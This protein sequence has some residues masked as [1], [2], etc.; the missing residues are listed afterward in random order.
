MQLSKLKK[1]IQ[2]RTDN[3]ARHLAFFAM[4]EDWFILPR[5][6]ADSYTGWLAFPLTVR[7]GA[8]FRRRDLQLFL[9][10]RNIQTR[11]VFTGNVLRQPLMKGIRIVTSRKG[12]KN[13]DA[14]MRG[15]ILIA[16]HH[17]LQEEQV[18]HMY[19]SFR[20]FAKQYGRV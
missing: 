3:F 15:G 20:E 18:E 5:Q 10:N 2:A 6:I 16:C 13:A 9:E 17:G 1:N 19:S 7:D 12:Y 4:Y 14:V 11:T 8:P